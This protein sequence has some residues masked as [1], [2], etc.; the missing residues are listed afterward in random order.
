MA[1]SESECMTLQNILA[2][3]GEE[4]LQKGFQGVSL[5]NI[6]KK[7]G[8]TTGAFYGYF[9]S[10]EELF[11]ALVK[12]EYAHILKMY[13]ATLDD[14]QRMQPDEQRSCMLEYTVTEMLRMTDYIYDHFEAFK[15]ILCCSEGTPYEHLLHDMSQMDYDATHVFYDTMNQNGT[16]MNTVHPQLEHMLTSGMFCAFFEMVVHDIPKENT[17]EYIRQLVQ[18]Y[19]AGW[20]RIMGF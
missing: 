4:F 5:R 7:A 2:A 3:A 20:Q 1:L 19:E 17:E 12:N 6:V 15:L 9:K 10:K 13:R 8:V 16:P 14:F 18:F 11:D